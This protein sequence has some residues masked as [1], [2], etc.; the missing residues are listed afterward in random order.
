MKHVVTSCFGSDT[1]MQ[2]YDPIF[3]EVLI[4][5]PVQFKLKFRDVSTFGRH[6]I[7]SLLATAANSNVIRAGSC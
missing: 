6:C 3:H 1:N 7:R 5:G 4:T 2:H